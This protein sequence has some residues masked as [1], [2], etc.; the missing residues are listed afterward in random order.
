MPE[1]PEV[2]V[3]VRGIAP[4]V[5]GRRIDR[6]VVRQADLRRP[7]P[8]T[9][10][11]TLAG[12]TIETVHRRGKFIL[13]DVAQRPADDLD[14]ARAGTLL[15]HLG[16]TGTLRV[17]PADTP[18]RPHDHVDLVLGDRVLRFNDPRRFGLVVW[19]PR[20]DGPVLDSPH[21]EK[22][23]VEP[24]SK[25][26]AG[27]AGGRLL[28][29]LSRGRTVAIKPFLL[30]GE[31]VVGVGNIYASESLFRA[32]IRPTT[33]AGRIALPRY[34]VL[35]AAIRETL[36]AA[37]DQGGSTLRDFVGADGARGYFQHHAYVYDREG[38]PCR[39]CGTPIRMIRQGQ[40]ATF[41]CPHCQR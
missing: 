11:A 9:L 22:L 41:H 20:S 29:R 3:T 27:D 37:I 36:A 34:L 1:L 33:P 16:M 38:L 30:A 18:L 6:V 5:V 21:F 7:V 4:G 26:F 23:G 19:H 35:A 8:D 15:V 12:T 25:A 31:A 40:R 2:E 10:A 13:V 17:M 28:F 32:R 24:F 39:V 14:P